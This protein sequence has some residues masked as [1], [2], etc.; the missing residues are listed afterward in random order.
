[1]SQ[2]LRQMCAEAFE[3][4]MIAVSGTIFGLAVFALWHYNTVFDGFIV[5][6]ACVAIVNAVLFALCL[7]GTVH[8]DR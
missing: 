4:C 2:S 5:A 7:R 1:M 3:V 6:I 8:R